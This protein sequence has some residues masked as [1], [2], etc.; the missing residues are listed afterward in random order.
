VTA[1]PGLYYFI[2]SSALAFMSFTKMCSAVIQTWSPKSFPCSTGDPSPPS[3]FAIQPAVASSPAGKLD[4]TG[5]V[6]SAVFSRGSVRSPSYS[7]V[8]RKRLSF[9]FWSPCLNYIFVLEG[10]PAAR[11]IKM[12]HFKVHFTF[13]QRSSFIGKMEV[14]FFFSSDFFITMFSSQ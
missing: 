3:S 9:F 12:L 5:C 13:L 10:G 14:I 7:S 4:V 11:S 2:S 6:V 8:Q 1:V